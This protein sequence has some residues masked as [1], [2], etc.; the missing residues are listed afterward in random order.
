MCI[1]EILF[2]YVFSFSYNALIKYLY[3]IKNFGSINKYYEIFTF[4]E[5]EY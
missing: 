2:V 5:K 1:E 3:G 4:W